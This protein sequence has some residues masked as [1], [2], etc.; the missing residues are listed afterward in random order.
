MVFYV[1]KD[2]MLK[3]NRTV[4]KSF[5]KKAKLANPEVLDEMFSTVYKKDHLG[6]FKYK[7]IYERT[8]KMTELFQTEK[9]FESRNVETGYLHM[10]T[11]L[12]VNGISLE[13]TED[14]INALV[15]AMKEKKMSYNDLLEW[16]LLHAKLSRHD[17][18]MVAGRYPKVF[19]K[20]LKRSENV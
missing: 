5:G 8:A 11:S 15:S 3:L 17:E 16:I 6:L 1:T 20:R 9:P 13:Y 7:N 10:L 18:A 14:D 19:E 12:D 2:Q 4:C